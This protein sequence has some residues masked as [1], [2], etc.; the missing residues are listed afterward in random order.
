MRIP[1]QTSYIDQKNTSIPLRRATIES[2]RP[3]L[4]YEEGKDLLGQL[5]PGSRL[6]NDLQ[7]ALILK[8]GLV[9]IGDSFKVYT[10]PVYEKL[11]GGHSQEL[12]AIRDQAVALRTNIGEIN[13]QDQEKARRACSNTIATFTQLI[14]KCNDAKKA[15]ESRRT[16]C[17]KDLKECSST[18][19]SVNAKISD[20]Q[21]EI[22]SKNTQ[23]SSKK[24]ELRQ[25]EREL[26]RLKSD[27]SKAQDKLP[28]ALENLASAAL[29]TGVAPAMGLMS[30]F[31][32]RKVFPDCVNLKSAVESLRESI[33]R[34]HRCID[35]ANKNESSLK[36]AQSRLEKEISSAKQKKA[37]LESELKTAQSTLSSKDKDLKAIAKKRTAIEQCREKVAT[38]KSHFYLANNEAKDAE[39]I[40]QEL[41]YSERQEDIKRSVDSIHQHIELAL[42]A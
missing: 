40:I 5:E 14:T 27:L 19:S 26:E 8:N 37:T 21:K 7:H 25:T 24:E 41:S 1:S 38:I 39:M 13:S 4:S 42:K 34:I 12:V 22:D 16:V 29:V 20:K 11:L 18:I 15:L 2:R 28:K 30:A 36:S 10:V 35:Q 33:S 6:F 17:D 32:P 3:I 23:L 31:L 9:T